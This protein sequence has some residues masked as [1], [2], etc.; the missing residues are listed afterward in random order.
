M[1]KW[2]DKAAR[3]PGEKELDARHAAAALSEHT[4]ARLDAARVARAPRPSKPWLRPHPDDYP[5]AASCTIKGELKRFPPNA[6]SSAHS[7]LRERLLAEGLIEVV[8]D[9]HPPYLCLGLRLTAK[10]K[11]A[12]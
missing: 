4:A 8:R 9:T 6:I 1:P 2:I 7:P 3:R 10:G 11:A 12:R 5:P